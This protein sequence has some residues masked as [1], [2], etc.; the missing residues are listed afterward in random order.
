MIGAFVV[1]HNLPQ[2][3]DLVY[4]HLKNHRRKDEVGIVNRSAGINVH[5]P[6]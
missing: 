2:L 4:K 5:H 3:A 6:K 1:R